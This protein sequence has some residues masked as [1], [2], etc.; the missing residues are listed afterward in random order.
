MAK[1]LEGKPF[2]LVATHCQQRPKDSVVSYIKSKGLAA[3]TPNMTVSSFGGH[4]KVKG[5]GYVPYYMVFDHTGKLSHHHMCGAYHGGDGLRMIEI[6]DELLAETPA[7]YL[8]Q[9]PYTHI[10]SLAQQVAKKRRLASAIKRIEAAR[11]A[12]DMAAEEA[13]EYERLYAVVKSYRDRMLARA[14]K[15]AATKPGEVVDALKS[16]VK[17]L[18]GTALA[19][20]V[21]DQLASMSRAPELRAAIALEKK[22]AKILRGLEKRKE[23]G[24]LSDKSRKKAVAKMSALLEDGGADLPFAESVRKAIASWAK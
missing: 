11:T 14:A 17:E 22:L 1:R 16:L 3:D 8:G 13:A 6:V 4:P 23:K 9:E 15:L 10:D 24:T 12:E 7:I 20:S 2:H 19:M 18:K 5:T 21:E